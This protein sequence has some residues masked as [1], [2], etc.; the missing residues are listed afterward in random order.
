MSKWLSPT[1]PNSGG[2][3]HQLCAGCQ[4][5]LTLACLFL[6]PE[7]VPGAHLQGHTSSLCTCIAASQEVNALSVGEISQPQMPLVLGLGVSL[8]PNRWLI[9]FKFR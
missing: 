6:R 4:L 9:L 1:P 2:Q 5:L 3:Q 7:G 8:Q